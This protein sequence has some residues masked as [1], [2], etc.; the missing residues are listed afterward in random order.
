MSIVQALGLRDIGVI[1]FT[2]HESPDPPADRHDRADRLVL[3]RDGFTYAAAAFTPLWLL[4]KQQWLAFV[5]YVGVFAAVVLVLVAADMPPQ[6]Y[7]L[8]SSALH[9]LVGFEADSIQRWTLSRR[10]YTMIGTVSG[11]NQM[12][13]ERQFLDS[14]LPQQ[15]MIAPSHHASSHGRLTSAADG[16][17]SSGFLAG[18]GW[19]GMLKRN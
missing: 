6:W 4:L 7:L 14:W 9:L 5:I 11:R 2:V 16:M 10:G 1:T 15:P 18:R 17:T 19:R 13:C 8:A 12:E 3:V